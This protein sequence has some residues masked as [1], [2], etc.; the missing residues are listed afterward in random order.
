MD[1]ERDRL[2]HDA[3][4]QKPALYPLGVGCQLAIHGTRHH[5]PLSRL[6]FPKLGWVGHLEGHRKDNG[7]GQ[8]DS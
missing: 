3:S 5:T 4:P 8:R 2:G 6:L 7:P 1:H